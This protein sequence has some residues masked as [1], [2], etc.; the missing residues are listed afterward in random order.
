MEF[1]VQGNPLAEEE[2]VE[3][4]KSM[5]SPPPLPLLNVADDAVGQ[6]ISDAMSLQSVAVEVIETISI[7]PAPSSPRSS[8]DVYNGA[9]SSCEEPVSTAT[10]PV[11]KF[12][13]EES[14]TSTVKPKARGKI[15][16]ERGFT[17]VDWL[18]LTR[19][20]SDLAG[21]HCICT[22]RPMC[23]ISVR[24]ALCNDG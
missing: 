4:P 22:Y 2:D 5:P 8:Q 1:P 23:I 21:M 7:S 18:K 15:P 20:E 3:S 17:Q 12:S 13:G 11:P 19:I 14:Q 16:L 9:N 24:K 10:P 6:N